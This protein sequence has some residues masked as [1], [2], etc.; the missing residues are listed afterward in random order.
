MLHGYDIQQAD[1]RFPW[2]FTFYS[3]SLYPPGG[4]RQEGSCDSLRLLGSVCFEG[5]RE[6]VQEAVRGPFALS[7]RKLP[8]SEDG[9]REA[10]RHN[11]PSC[12][13][14]GGI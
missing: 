7:V 2:V 14:Y 8:L 11:G 6:Y 13:P 9:F 4:P 5:G 12:P 1:V 3:V 10:Y